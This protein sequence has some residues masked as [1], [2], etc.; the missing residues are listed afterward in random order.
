M[1][2]DNWYRNFNRS[3]PTLN[4]DT[5]TIDYFIKVVNSTGLA[6]P[7][8]L[9]MSGWSNGAAFGE[10]YAI[11]TPGIAAAAVYSAPDPF[12]DAVDRCA[13]VPLPTYATPILDVHNQCDLW[14]TSLIVE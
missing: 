5:Q 11:V 8:R 6:D 4:A 7:R 14:G 13:M 9:F 12:R 2:L 1:T 10:Q 3:D